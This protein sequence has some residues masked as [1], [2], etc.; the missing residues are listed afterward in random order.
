MD[1]ARYGGGVAASEGRKTDVMWCH[2]VIKYFLLCTRVTSKSVQYDF[3][4]LNE[5]AQSRAYLKPVKN[6]ILTTREIY[7]NKAIK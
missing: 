5:I 1:S 7:K 4:T 2:R 6:L 3:V